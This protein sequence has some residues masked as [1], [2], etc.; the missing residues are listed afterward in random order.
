MLGEALKRLDEIDVKLL[1]ALTSDGRASYRELAK[2]LGISVATVAYRLARLQ[3][4]GIIKGFTAVLDH[5]ALGYEITA[6]IGIVIR[7][8]KLLEVQKEI[9]KDPNVLAVY[10]VTGEIDSIVIARFRDRHE[11]SQFVK[12]VLGMQYVERTATH[13]VLEVVKESL[14]TPLLIE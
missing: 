5:A 12:R 14:T 2:R 9:A 10:D 11:L 8:G 6:V 3:R 1:K 13:I 4:G 7:E